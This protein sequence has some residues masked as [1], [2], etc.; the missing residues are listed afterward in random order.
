MRPSTKVLISQSVL[1]DWNNPS[2]CKVL[3]YERYVNGLTIEPSDSMKNGLIF[4]SKLLGKSRN[5]VVWEFPK[6]KSGEKSKAE[7]DIDAIV[8]KAKD[9][10]K[11]LELVPIEVQPAWHHDNLLAHPDLICISVLADK[12]IVD[13]K[14]CG[15]SDTDRFN[16]YFN[17]D[18]VDTLQPL[19]YSYMYYLMNNEWL[20]FFYFVFF[21]NGGVKII[22]VKITVSGIDSHKVMI[23]QF[24]KDMK[25]FDVDSFYGTSYNQCI[26]CPLFQTCEKRAKVPAVEEMVV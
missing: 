25:H 1:R 17:L 21:K 4:E 8:E 5:D 13:V 18:N 7:Q 23:N 20:P 15:F 16:P 12:A 22:D 11:R 6:L 9:L 26:K 24:R 10:F 2:F 3:W 14:Y 19:H